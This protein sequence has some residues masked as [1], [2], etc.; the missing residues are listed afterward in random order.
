MRGPFKPEQ[1]KAIL[2]LMVLICSAGTPH[3]TA[4]AQGPEHLDIWDSEYLQEVLQ[5]KENRL[6]PFKQR[7]EIAEK[8]KALSQQELQLSE[9]MKRLT[10]EKLARV[11]ADDERAEEALNAAEDD[12]ELTGLELRAMQKEVLSASSARDAVEARRAQLETEI[13]VIRLKLEVL[14]GPVKA[15]WENLRDA[16]EKHALSRLKGARAEQTQA[17]H[18][19][20]AAEAKVVAARKKTAISKGQVRKAKDALEELRRTREDPKLGDA[21][22][23]V[24]ATC[25]SP[26]RRLTITPDL[27]FNQ[28]P[29]ST[30]LAQVPFLTRVCNV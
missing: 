28:P 30:R 5:W 4:G 23:P 3:L 8:R 19:L 11:K 21:S 17:E 6:G 9:E 13:A 2:V 24:S 7:L 15:A 14:F 20:E 25:S 27:Q 18:E 12:A 1:R 26:L 22:Q 16:E 10:E 29:R